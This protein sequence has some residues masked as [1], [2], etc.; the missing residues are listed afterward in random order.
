VL[1]VSAAPDGAPGTPRRLAVR[2]PDGARRVRL[3]GDATGWQPVDLAFEPAGMWALALA[4]APGPHRVQLQVDD[5]PW[6]SPA[7]LPAVDDDL[8]GPAGLLVA[9]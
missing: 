8:V 6:R 5:G 9:P 1:D 7:N 2:A 3:R 4:L